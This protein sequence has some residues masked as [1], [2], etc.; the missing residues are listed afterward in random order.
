MQTQPRLNGCHN[1]PAKAGTYY[2]QDGYFSPVHRVGAVERPARFV[3]IKH[4]MSEDCVYSKHT[5]DPGCAGCRWNHNEQQSKAA[6]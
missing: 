6:Q 4:V 1:R 2:A 3:P 5:A